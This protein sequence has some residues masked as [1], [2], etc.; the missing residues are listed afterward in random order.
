MPKC[1]FKLLTGYSCPGCGI[2]RALHAALHGDLM[3]AIHYNYFL[4]YSLP[5]ALL[6]VFERWVLSECSLQT[7]IRSVCENPKIVQLYV[8][9]F[10]IW[11]IVRNIYD[12]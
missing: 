4:V 6:L 7:K 5:Y 2:Q 11:F 10:T 12:L 9:L 8:V 3:K 1:P